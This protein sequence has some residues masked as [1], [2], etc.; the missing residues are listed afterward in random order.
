[1]LKPSFI[2]IISLFIFSTV[3]GQT[4]NSENYRVYS[5]LIEKEIQDTTNSI[6]IIKELENNKYEPWVKDAIESRNREQLEQLYF[7]T[8][9]T[10]GNI[11]RPIDSVTQTLILSYYQTQS[12]KANLTNQFNVNAQI[13]L[14]S[15]SSFK[16][17]LKDDWGSF[18]K[19]YPGSGGAFQFSNI[20]YSP[21]NATAVFYY[22]HG[23]NGLNGH[24]SL[25]VMTK[26]D[27]QWHLKY[28]IYL[29]QS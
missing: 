27:N 14:V 13:F 20:Y 19:K 2:L 10:N 4:F 28:E 11:V 29:W 17:S 21:D 15:K 7:W 18:Y 9:D 24:G 5:A 16:K 8:R 3:I 22:W 6:T 23:R 25:A 1:M 12:N 26:M